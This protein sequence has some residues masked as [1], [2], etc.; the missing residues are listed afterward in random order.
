MLIEVSDLS[1]IS[2]NIVLYRLLISLV[3]TDK[4]LEKKQV[5]IKVLPPN[6]GSVRSKYMYV[7]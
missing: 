5:I 2:L 7:N 3:K 4:N 6:S 1:P